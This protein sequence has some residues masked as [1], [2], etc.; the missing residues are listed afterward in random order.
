MKRTDF[1]PKATSSALFSIPLFALSE[2]VGHKVTV[3]LFSGERFHGTLTSI[4]NMGERCAA[5]RGVT[6]AN[7]ASHLQG[8]VNFTLSKVHY[9]AKDGAIDKMIRVTIRGSN[10]RLIILPK[11]LER[12]PFFQLDTQVDKVRKERKRPRE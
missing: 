4:D 6:V 5:D 9:T 7:L 10:V 12:A 8:A 3:E 11:A 1:K 2:S